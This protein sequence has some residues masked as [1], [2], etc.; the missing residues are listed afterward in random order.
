MLKFQKNY[1]IENWSHWKQDIH[2]AVEL[3]AEEFSVYPNILQTNGHTGSQ[4][5][6]IV[7]LDEN[8]RLNVVNSKTAKSPSAGEEV[9]LDAFSGAN[10]VLEFALDDHLPDLGI[11]LIFDDEPEW[12]NDIP[13]NTPKMTLQLLERP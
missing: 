10:Y 7:N 9:I 1:N 6:S 5:D 11:R 8:E 2:K 13:D 3:F 12:E 4:F